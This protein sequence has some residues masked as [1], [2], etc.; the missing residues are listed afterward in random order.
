MA[1][2]SRQT[3]L[4]RQREI[5]KAE[6]AQQKRMKRFGLRAPGELAAP[7]EEDGEISA[8]EDGETDGSDGSPV[9]VTGDAG[10]P[11]RSG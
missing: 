6:K 8:S 9:E 11:T 1:K 5:G 4:K 7:G 2:R 10:T 3:M